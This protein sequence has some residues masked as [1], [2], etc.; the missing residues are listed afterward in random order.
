MRKRLASSV[1]ACKRFR[2]M[3]PWGRVLEI[4]LVINTYLLYNLMGLS[5]I[6]TCAC[7]ES[8]GTCL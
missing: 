5:Q 6:S 4:I 3:S 8:K 7:V 1:D 2:K